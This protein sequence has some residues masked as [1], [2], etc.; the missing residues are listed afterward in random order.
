[1][2]LFISKY[3]NVILD[4]FYHI[5]NAELIKKIP[6]ST[7]VVCI[8]LNLI[9]YVFKMSYYHSKNIDYAYDH[10]QK[11]CFRFLEYIE[12][13]NCT[14]TLHNLNNVDAV[15][16]IYKKTIDDLNAPISHSFHSTCNSNLENLMDSNR[17]TPNQTNININPLL[18]HPSNHLSNHFIYES[19]IIKT[20][21]YATKVLIFFK[22]EFYFE[23]G[24][25]EIKHVQPNTIENMI[26]ITKHYLSKFLMYMDYPDEEDPERIPFVQN[27]NVLF[28][29]I[30]LIQEKIDFNAETYYLFLQEVLKIMVKWRN[31]EIVLTELMI[32]YKY[33]ELFYIEENTQKLMSLFENGK[34]K[35]FVK[36]LFSFS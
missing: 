1:M 7:Y 8:G 24:S 14:N 21:T 22:N 3:G 25:S 34:M 35:L 27:Y 9:I 13:M 5:E 33:M 10:T 15:L 11:A 12:Q 2:K 18:N 6:N 17:V 16:F 36:M 31:S 20:I 30:K 26:Y 4:Y 23:D 29:Y 28:Y 32:Q 19:K